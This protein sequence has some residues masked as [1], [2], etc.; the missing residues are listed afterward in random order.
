MKKLTI[1]LL[2]LCVAA[3][4]V[5]FIPIVY[6]YITTRSYGS[7][8]YELNDQDTRETATFAGGC[9]WCLEPPFEEI[10]GVHE[11]VAGYTGGEEEN[12]SY[13]EV[14]GG[15][16]GH[17]EAVQIVFDP[18]MVSYEDLL[19]IYW[20]QID[21]TDEE[22]QFVD[23]GEQYRAV[24]FYHSDD[25]RMLA[26]SSKQTLDASGRFDDPVVTDIEP[27]DTFYRAEEYH[28]NYYQTNSVRYEFYF[29]NSG[30]EEFFEEYWEEDIDYQ[31]AA[32][33]DEDVAFWRQY[34]R[35]DDEE[36]L[37]RLTDA[38]YEVTQEASAEEP[39]DNEYWD[40]FEEGIY[41]DILSGEPL[42]SSVHKFDSEDGRPSFTQPILEETIVEEGDWSLLVRRTE[43]KSR[44]AD[45]HL[46]H[47]FNDGPEPGGLRYS[48]NSEALEFVAKDE[49]ELR[50][51]G[52]F[53]FLFDDE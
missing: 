9:F 31:V 37:N 32:P 14:S 34:E 36:L 10:E 19:Q 4:G 35:G 26:E 52:E 47:V 20:R 6:D 8:P 15:E 33:A 2:T 1:L 13:E 51:Y 11:V 50:D 49:M 17:V 38:E 53:L 23:R 24:I 46:G 42:F 3:A 25:Q 41:V 48:V 27:A 21:P 40:H 28:Q 12:P 44:Y 18:D 22:G 30:R 7:E 29:S 16:T 45:S 43:I 39:Y 5:I